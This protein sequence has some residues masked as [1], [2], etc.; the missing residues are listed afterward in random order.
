MT[1]L[2]SVLDLNRTR[3]DPAAAQGFNR[4][5]GII[6]YLTYV[7][8]LLGVLPG[9]DDLRRL[10]DRRH[11]ASHQLGVPGVPQLGGDRELPNCTQSNDKNTLPAK[12]QRVTKDSWN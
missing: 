6:D 10:A 5:D 2:L 12:I 11:Q 9:K 3:R 1:H 8:D 4:T 7:A